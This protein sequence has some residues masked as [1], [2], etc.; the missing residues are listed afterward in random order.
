MLIVRREPRAVRAPRRSTSCSTSRPACATQRVAI[1]GTG[2]AAAVRA[3]PGVRRRRGRADEDRA[4]RADAA[5]R[6]RSCC[7][8]CASSSPT[9]RRASSSTCAR[10]G[11]SPRAIHELV[12]LLL[13]SDVIVREGVMWRAR[14]RGK[15]AQMT[16]PKTYDDARRRAPARDGRRPSA[17]CSRWRPSSARRRGSTRSSRSSARAPARRS[18]PTARRSRRSRR[19]GDHSRLAV[20]AAVGKLVERE[21]LVEVAA[22]VD[23]GRA[24]AAVRVPEPVAARL[25]GHRRARKRRAYHARRRALARAAPRGPRARPRRKR[26]ARHLALAGD[27]AR[28]RD[29]ATAAP[30]RPRARSTRTRRRSGCSTARSPASATQRP[31]GAHPPVAR[32]R[33]GLRADRRLR[34]G[35]RRVRAHAAAVVGRREQDQGGGRVQQDGPR[36][37]PQGRPQARARVPRARPRAVP[38]RRRR[39]RHRRLARRHR[40]V[41]ADARPLRRGAR[42]DHRGARAPRQGR[43]Q[44]RDRDVAVA[45]RR[46]PDRSRPVRGARYTCHKEALE[47]RKQAGDR[48]GQIVSRRTTSPRSRSSS[49]TSPRR[50]PAGSP[51]C[52]GRGRSARCRWPR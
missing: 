43:R 22:V 26:S 20:V 14:R 27:A 50:A 7:A 47:L 34:G 17:A 19:R 4:R 10:C 46:R 15:L 11:G 32:P 9:C 18:I 23:A 51:R 2:D 44:A 42:E 45:P 12:R 6:P 21:W 25:Q 40:Q 52:R 8:S 28:G 48:W 39:A 24:R 41:A 33:L 31:R 30:P 37:A 3:P 13:E 36:V 29:R 35:A 49:A 5:P 38:R 16:L 1:V